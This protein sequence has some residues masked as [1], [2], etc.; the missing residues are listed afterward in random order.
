MRNVHGSVLKS[1]KQPGKTGTL[2][3]LEGCCL[4]EGDILKEESSPFSQ[5]EKAQFKHFS[6]NRPVM[7]NG[8]S[9][10]RVMIE[11]DSG[12]EPTSS[13]P[14]LS[15]L[16]HPRPTH[17]HR[18]RQS[19]LVPRSS[20]LSDHSRL[21]ARPEQVTER[22]LLLGRKYLHEARDLHQT[23]KIFIHL[24]S[25]GQNPLIEK[26]LNGTSMN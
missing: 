15:L 23:S 10:L 7:P 12:T 22:R 24:F 16:T 20:N 2:A 26:V 18:S 8:T 25:T 3:T 6:N 11:K 14:V 19:R 17:T 13:S 4:E 21:I 5:R 9:S 1:I